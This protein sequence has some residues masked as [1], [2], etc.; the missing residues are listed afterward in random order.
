MPSAPAP[1]HSLS[2]HS[3]AADRS[4]TSP[5]PA[6]S[7]RPPR[8]ARHTGTSHQRLRH[9]HPHPRRLRHKTK[10][11]PLP[12]LLA[13]LHPTFPTQLLLHKFSDFTSTMISRVVKQFPDL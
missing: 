6:E 11:H 9:Q 8:P 12:T 5:A 2:T 3:P 13:A 7:V 1:S 10:F 4:S